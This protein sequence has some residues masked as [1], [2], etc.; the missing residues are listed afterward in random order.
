MTVR[1]PG[2]PPVQ[3]GAHWDPMKDVIG[4]L[5]MPAPPAGLE[6]NTSVIFSSVCQGWTSLSHSLT[7]WTILL[8]SDQISAKIIADYNTSIQN[9][10]EASFIEDL[11]RTCKM[12]R[13][14]TKSYII[15]R[16]I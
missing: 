14:N 8:S 10:K 9:I 1:A 7:S 11:L 6:I 3:D 13:K 15:F 2:N 5:C 12:K 16:I 4:S